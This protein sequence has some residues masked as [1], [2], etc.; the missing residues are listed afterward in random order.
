MPFEDAFWETVAKRFRIITH[1]SPRHGNVHL[2]LA[3]QNTISNWRAATFSSKEPET[4]EWIDGFES[5]WNFVDVGANVGLYSIYFLRVHT[6][7]ALSIEPSV[8]NLHQLALNLKTNEVEARAMLFPVAMGSERGIAELK[9]GNLQPA[10]AE[11]SAGDIVKN[12]SLQYRIFSMRLDDLIPF[13]GENYAVKID[14]DGLELDILKGGKKFL[15][16]SNCRSLMLE[17]DAE[18]SERRLEIESLL[19]GYG[20]V[21]SSEDVSD[22]MSSQSKSETVNQIWAKDLAR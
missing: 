22:L 6:G 9:L 8:N 1:L 16:S 21:L 15:S 12:W 3:Q 4:L 14:V 5:T 11:T 17:N 10:A 2:K 20:F 19:R 18:N 7:Q 13:A